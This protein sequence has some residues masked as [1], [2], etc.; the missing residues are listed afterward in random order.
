MRRSQLYDP[1]VD[2]ER[3]EFYSRNSSNTHHSLFSEQ[4]SHRSV[5]PKQILSRPNYFKDTSLLKLKSILVRLL[6]ITYSFLLILE[7]AIFFN[8]QLILLN[9]LFL[10][11]IVV[12]CYV[13]VHIRHGLEDRW[14]SLSILFFIC[15]NSIPLWLLEITYSSMLSVNVYNPDFIKFDLETHFKPYNDSKAILSSVALASGQSLNSDTAWLDQINKD[16]YSFMLELHEALFCFILIISRILLPQVNLTWAAISSISEFSFNT[17]L[18]VYFTMSMCREAKHKLPESVVIVSFVV[19]SAALLPIALNL[20][21]D[22]SDLGENGSTAAAAAVSGFRISSLRR[23]TDNFYFNFVIQI[24]FTDVP[25]LTVRLLIMTKLKYV[26]NE[27]YYLIAKQILILICKL[28]V[29]FYNWARGFLK[30]CN[31]EDLLKLNTA[32]VFDL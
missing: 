27:F 24:V 15:A 2:P 14:C 12:D 28:A 5:K 1:F 18:D 26:K 16:R 3:P 32:D 30:A 4:L 22:G 11:L 13:V 9:M 31:L 29:M 7:T 19:S 10:V 23:L 21:P 6:M 8:E 20:C 25:L 17:I